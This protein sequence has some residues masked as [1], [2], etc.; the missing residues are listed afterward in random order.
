M[1]LSEYIDVL[2]ALGSLIEGS[3]FQG[4]VYSVGGCERDRI[5]GYDIK[6]IDLVVDIPNG[7][8]HLAEW[9]YENGHLVYA[10]VTYENYGTA[11]FRL[12]SAP[13]IE[14]E[15]V[16]TRKESY[17]DMTTRNPETAYGTIQED[18]MRRDFTMNALYRTVGTDELHD[19]TGR[20]L[21]DIKNRI[22]RSCDDPDII[23]MEDPL[24]ILRAIRFSGK[25]GWEIEE[26]TR[27]GMERNVKR[28]EIISQERITDELNKI[29]CFSNCSRPLFMIWDMG[30]MKYV[31]K[32]LGAM[33]HDEFVD[34]VN[35]MRHTSPKLEL[36]IP[37]LFKNV[38]L[39]EV[40][41][42][43]MKYSCDIIKNALMIMREVKILRGFPDNYWDISPVE[44]RK[45]Q[46]RVGN[47]Q[48]FLHV[49]LVAHSIN[50]K[51]NP[52]VRKNMQAMHV[53]ARNIRLTMN[54]DSCYDYKLPVDGDDV[55][56]LKGIGPGKV[57]KKY[58]DYLM[59]E[60]FKNPKIT[61]GE[62][63]EL[64]SKITFE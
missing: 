17:R 33:S 53:L 45:M 39:P 47:P 26:N 14:L 38:V 12:K 58:L 16:Q 27:K 51:D 7:G 11:M 48:D 25:L 30:A 6:D 3:E 32:Q 31:N 2:N 18:C 64:L 29:L 22:I 36:R 8:I 5:L 54:N 28:L 62:C 42:R 59:E 49:V 10:P 46:Y 40:A 35:S 13:E 50:N 20:S 44:V 55:M 24:R 23:F 9:L 63:V 61:R 1:E 34:V 15:A 60:A 57:I 37:I 43:D 21:D 41:M 19:F 4:H 52:I 56:S